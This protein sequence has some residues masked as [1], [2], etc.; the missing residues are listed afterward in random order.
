MSNSQIIGVFLLFS[1]SFLGCDFFEDD[2]VRFDV[3]SEGSFSGVHTK[4]ETIVDSQS[5][6]ISVWKQH[7]SDRIPEPPLPAVDFTSSV[8]VAIFAGDKPDTCYRLFLREVSED[9]DDIIIRYEIGKTS[10]D[11][12]CGDAITQ[13]FTMLRI[14]KPQGSISIIDEGSL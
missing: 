1:F 12:G 5:E 13:P 2:I 11:S 14:Q 10:S 3:V 6:W 9:G 4:T 8:V 7:G